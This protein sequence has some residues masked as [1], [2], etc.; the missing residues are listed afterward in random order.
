M[1]GRNG[2]FEKSVR[3]RATKHKF[4]RRKFRRNSRTTCYG[5]LTSVWLAVARE[6]K[7]RQT[8]LK[9]LSLIGAWLRSSV[10]INCH[11]YPRKKTNFRLCNFTLNMRQRF[12]QA[13]WIIVW[14]WDSILLRNWCL[15]FCFT[16]FFVLCLNK[17]I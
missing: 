12:N 7:T 16:L 3:P 17:V 13:G 8:E 10:Q 11:L 6:G 4:L 9:F 15:N 14:N 5:Y 1:W 2:S